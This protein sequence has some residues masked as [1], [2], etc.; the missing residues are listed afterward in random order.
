MEYKE[1]I[2]EAYEKIDNI[3]T[4]YNLD[5]EDAILNIVYKLVHSCGDNG[6]H[7]HDKELKDLIEKEN[8]EVEKTRERHKHGL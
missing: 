4:D 5:E 6:F 7:F 3:C 8:I 1:Y 2:K